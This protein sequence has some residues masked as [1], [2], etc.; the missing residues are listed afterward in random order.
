MAGP[1]DAMAAGPGGRGRLR[2]SHADRELVVSALK[3]AFVQGR[4]TK[5]EL[6]ARMDLAFTARTYTDLAV[7]TADLP[8][9]LAAAEPLQPT[10]P[11]GEQPVVRPGRA[12]AMATTAYAGLCAY[13]LLLTPHG[14]DN[15][16]AL[17][18]IFGGFVVYLGILLICVS[19]ILI[20]RQD[21]RSSG[22]PPRRPNAGG[23]PSRGL[24][25]AGPGGGHVPPAEPGHWPT[26]KA[27]RKRR[28]RPPLPV[29]Y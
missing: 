1:G 27:A 10:R 5:D 18:L 22:Q 19:A 12:I 7:L 17:P 3:A 4:L 16:A 14:G 2:A 23:P 13:G 25:R 9:G 28:P 20:S 8:P 21:K 29:A 15:T 26:A 6:D 11:R 24:P